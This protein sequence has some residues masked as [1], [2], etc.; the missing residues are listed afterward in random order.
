MAAHSLASSALFAVA[1]L[2]LACLPPAG[3]LRCYQGAN[4]LLA[5]TS[6]AIQSSS[7]LR[8]MLRPAA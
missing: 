7:T 3:A 8:V 6:P 2:A 1:C 4:F 5:S